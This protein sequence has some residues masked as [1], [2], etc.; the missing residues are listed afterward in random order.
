[1]IYSIT[2]ND[3]ISNMLNMCKQGDTIQLKPGIYK[4]KIAIFVDGV[5]IIGEDREN[6]IRTI[7]SAP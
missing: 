1:M 2:N 4:E 7:R 3:S 6:T 5:T